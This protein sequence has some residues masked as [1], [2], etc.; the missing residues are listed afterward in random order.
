[1]GYAGGPPSQREHGSATRKFSI[2]PPATA[3][4]NSALLLLWSWMEGSMRYFVTQREYLHGN[5]AELS[6]SLSE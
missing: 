3:A 5:W 1:M 4:D 6:V 2:L